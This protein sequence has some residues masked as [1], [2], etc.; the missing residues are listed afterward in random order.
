[1][2]NQI[3]TREEKEDLKKYD[4]YM[5]YY[6]IIIWTILSAIMI[7]DLYKFIISSIWYVLLYLLLFSL[8]YVHA[9][10]SYYPYGKEKEEI[11]NRRG[12]D[13]E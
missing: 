3:L 10:L 7:I 8:P 1:M 5:F 9:F 4:K 12:F 13:N 11:I 2:N 6:I